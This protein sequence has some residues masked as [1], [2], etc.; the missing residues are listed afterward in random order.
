MAQVPTFPATLFFCCDVAPADGGETPIVR[1]DIVYQKAKEA[2]PDFC[3]KLEA[4]GVYLL[5][6]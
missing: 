2:Y 5:L 1:S 6:I 4:E 3:A